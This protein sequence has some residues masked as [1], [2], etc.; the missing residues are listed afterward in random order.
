MSFWDNLFGRNLDFERDVQ[1]NVW[2]ALNPSHSNWT[3]GDYKRCVLTNPI[4]FACYELIAKNFS[5][6][7]FQIDGED[8][9]DNYIIKLLNNPNP[10]QSKQDFLS[11]YILNKKA[12][13]FNYIRPLKG[14]GA[15]VS[16]ALYNLDPACIDYQNNFPTRFAFSRSEKKV[17]SNKQFKYKETNQEEKILFDD[18]MMFF[19]TANGIKDNNLFAA[20]SRL[21]AV[22]RN[23]RNIETALIS[24][25]NALSKA[26][27][28]ILSGSRQGNMVAKPLDPKEKKDIE[29]KIASYGNGKSKGNVIATNSK[30]DV[31][32]LHIP[33]SQLGIPDAIAHNALQIM[34]AFGIHKD[35]LP[36]VADNGAKYENMADA[37]VSFIQNTVQDEVNDFC[38][39]ITSD[40]ELDKPLTG[41]L[42]HLP[43]MQTIENRK[44]DKALKISQVYRNVQDP[45]LANAIMEIAGIAIENEG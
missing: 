29:R 36:L 14:S 27:L 8:A 39:T 2:Y 25:S 44:A 19:D 6:V 12:Y 28:Y 33:M 20:P 13:G 38:N 43:D 21:D 23:I 45:T 1:G 4:L 30:M 31:Q 17:L 7:K 22:E 41:T 37:K 5:Q 16:S 42:D 32:S 15:Q 18:V 35:L 9:E 34:N 24:E 40:L 10:L 11:E 3:L 26:G